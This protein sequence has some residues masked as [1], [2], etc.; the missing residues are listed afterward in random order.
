MS[1]LGEQITRKLEDLF[2]EGSSDLATSNEQFRLNVRDG[3]RSLF[4]S[5]SS[6]WN[7]MVLMIHQGLTVTR[8]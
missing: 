7:S 3:I 4:H 2:L 1:V 5:L 8:C 6:Y